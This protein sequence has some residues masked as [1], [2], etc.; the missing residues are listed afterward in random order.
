MGD[1]SREREQAIAR[2]MMY[3][4]AALL[5]IVMIF[6]A[7]LFLSAELE[8]QALQK[9]ETAQQIALQQEVAPQAQRP[10]A[11]WRK[12]ADEKT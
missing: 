6:I 8:Q 12:R 1:L 5:S 9:T 10:W 4:V 7:G 2:S 3:L 11:L